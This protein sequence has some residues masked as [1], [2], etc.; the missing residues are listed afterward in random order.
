M[1]KKETGKVGSLGAT[2]EGCGCVDIGYVVFGRVVR[3][4]EC[5]ESAFR[6]VMG[7]Q[8]T[9]SMLPNFACDMAR[10]S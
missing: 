1:A 8:F 4:L 6:S 9:F 10:L 5:D 7:A 2:Y 3:E